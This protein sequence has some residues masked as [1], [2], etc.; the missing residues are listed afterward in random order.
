MKQ[1]AYRNNVEHIGGNIKSI[2]FSIDANASVFQMLTS[3][4]YND[5][6]KANIREWS[7]NACD[8]CLE[9]GVAVNFDVHLPTLSEPT[10][11]V[12]DYGTGLSPED[13]E[14]LFS[15]LGASTK[16]NSN[17]FNGTLGIGRMAGLAVADAF[18]VES[19]FNGKL[20]SYVISMQNGEPVTL[21]LGEEDTTEPNGLKLSVAVEASDFQTYREKASEV[22][23]YFDHKPNLNISDVNIDLDVSKHISDDWFVIKPYNQYDTTNYVV[24]SQVAY[25]IPRNSAVTTHDFRNL[26]IKADPGSVTFNPG[27]ESLSLNK[28]TIAYLN[29]AFNDVKDEYVLAATNAMIAAANDVELIETY[30]RLVSQAPSSVASEIDPTPFVSPEYASMFT[31]QHYYASHS[32]TASFRCVT[33]TVAFD[34]LTKDLVTITYKPKGYKT[35]RVMDAGNR[36]EFRSFFKAKHVIIDKK[37]NFRSSLNKHFESDSLVCWQRKGKSDIDTAVQEAKAHLDAMGI[38]YI[39]VSEISDDLEEQKPSAVREGL[40]AS[41]INST[42]VYRATKMDEAD[43]EANT[44]LYMKLHNTTPLL[45]DTSTSFEE[46]I[47]L[48]KLL[49]KVMCMPPIKG[50]AKRYQGIVDSLDNWIDFETYIKEKVAESTFKRPVTGITP[51]LSKDLISEHSKMLF[52]TEIQ[53]YFD[54]IGDYNEFMRSDNYIFD[55]AEISLLERF[56]ANFEEYVNTFKE[57]MEAL[58]E[59]Y[60]KTMELLTTRSWRSDITSNLVRYIAKLEAFYAVH[61]TEQQQSDTPHLEWVDDYNTQDI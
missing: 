8:A 24:M 57:D 47:Q 7:T 6:I 27:R 17:I 59:V 16:R 32:H 20:Y 3:D 25:E 50:V 15:T 61:T 9:A 19:Y 34:K 13:V 31:K 54:E 28:D 4:V 14:G 36:M 33:G 46:Y 10:F 29:K 39:L 45:N 58:Q 60:P 44:Y 55:S 52:P 41:T 18:T 23:I 37:S 11:F 35:S 42:C 48:Y 5:P 43:V 12:R 1:Q 56:N 51:Y 38:E 49:G 22:Y 2:G 40:Y 21:P 53:E 26:V 30:V